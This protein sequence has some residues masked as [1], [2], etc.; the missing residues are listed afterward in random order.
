[1]RDRFIDQMRGICILCVIAVHTN[2][3]YRLLYTALF[4]NFAVPMF[5]FLSVVCLTVK[6]NGKEICLKSFYRTRFVIIY[7]YLIWGTLYNFIEL[8]VIDN[9]SLESFLIYNLITLALG[10]IPTLYFVFALL[11]LYLIYPL[12]LSIFTRV[13]LYQLILIFLCS[14]IGLFTL[15]S[16][17]WFKWSYSIYSFSV[18][19]NLI[20]VDI[21]KTF[22]IFYMIP[23]ILLG[24]IFA[25]RYNEIRELLKRKSIKN[26]IIVNCSLALWIFIINQWNIKILYYGTE[27]LPYATQHNLVYSIMMILFI[28]T[29][30]N[31]LNKENVFLS[32]NGR[33]SRQLFFTHSVVLIFLDYILVYILKMRYTSS[34]VLVYLTCLLLIQALQRLPKKNYLF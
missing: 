27:R 19:S 7:P 28:F 16:I 22:F 24:F 3:F 12:L 29:I 15:Y 6:Y 13:K 20:A 33:I 23:Y 30:F 17:V 18:G 8:Y 11:Q 31:S 32:Y 9:Y 2:L 5:F 10:D 4:Y 34:F 1:M 21:A 26:P 14:I 25:F